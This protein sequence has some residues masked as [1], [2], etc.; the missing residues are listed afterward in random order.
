MRCRGRRRRRAPARWRS[1]G[2]G[3]G[4][5]PD[6]RAPSWPDGTAVAPLRCL[7]VGSGG[8][9]TVPVRTIAWEWGRIGCTGFGGPPAHIALLRDLCVE[10]RAWMTAA[11]FED[12]IGA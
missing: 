3:P 6:R 7:H 2:C 9:D 5:C 8:R 11:E 12:A 4:I 1:T 10:R